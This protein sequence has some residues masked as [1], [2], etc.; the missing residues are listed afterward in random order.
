MQHHGEQV[1][2]FERKVL[3]TV[4]GFSSPSLFTYGWIRLPVQAFLSCSHE[5]SSP[6]FAW[7]HACYI[8]L[9]RLAFLGPKAQQCKWT[10]PFG[11]CHKPARRE[12][13]EILTLPC[14]YSCFRHRCGTWNPESVSQYY[15]TATK[16]NDTG[17]NR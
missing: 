3:T 13:G 17:R 12:C 2:S 1:D 11:W 7:Q 4:A 5:T 6:F 15:R 16:C 10:N 8:M 14:I 9:R